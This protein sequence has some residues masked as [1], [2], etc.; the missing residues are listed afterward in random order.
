MEAREDGA[1][2]KAMANPARAADAWPRGQPPRGWARCADDAAGMAARHGLP[3][4]PRRISRPPLPRGH[5]PRVGRRGP[6]LDR[7]PDPAWHPR[8]HPRRLSADPRR[9]SRMSRVDGS[10]EPGAVEAYADLLS[11]RAGG[12]DR[13][14]LLPAVRGSGA[15]PADRGVRLSPSPRTSVDEAG[16]HGCIGRVC[17]R[18]GGARGLAAPIWAGWLRMNT[19]IAWPRGSRHGE[20]VSPATPFAPVPHGGTRPR[21]KGRCPPFT[22][23]CVHSRL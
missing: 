19:C 13:P 17:Y 20:T 3:H 12:G 1:L 14:P 23:A 5:G 7:S 8:P 11:T 15:V 22:R 2:G 21:S 18:V 10:P 9:L 6:H 4:E 16:G